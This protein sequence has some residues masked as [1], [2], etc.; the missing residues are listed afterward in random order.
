VKRIVFLGTFVLVFFVSLFSVSALRL[1]LEF[2]N[3]SAVL[4]IRPAPF[5][6]KVGY[7]LS[8]TLGSG[9]GDFV[10]VSLDYRIVDAYRLID[11]LHIFAGVG[12]YGQVYMDT[13][14]IRL[15]AR[16]PVGL[17]AFLLKN[18]FEIFLEIVPTVSFLPEIDFD[19]FQGYIGFTIKTPF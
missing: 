9:G 16:I 8:G 14:E 12:A 15:G 6:I 17:Q 10:H 5:D 11:F 19:G 13:E 4:V 7:N 1:G 2:G 18:T 3:P